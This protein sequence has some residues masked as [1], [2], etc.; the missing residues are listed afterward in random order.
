MR[1]GVLAAVERLG[2]HPE[3]YAVVDG[4]PRAVAIAN[5]VQAWTVGAV[6]AL[7]SGWDGRARVDADG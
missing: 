6:H 5:R 3:L 7:R 4:E 1:A 2:R